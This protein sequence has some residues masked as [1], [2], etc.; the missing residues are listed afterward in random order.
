VACES[1][2]DRFIIQDLK[3][4]II[5]HTPTF[6]RHAHINYATENA[7]CITGTAHHSLLTCH[8]PESPFRAFL[9]CPAPY[10]TPPCSACRHT[11]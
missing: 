11:P 6:S 7:H 9:D 1:A 10:P 3:Q 8:H 4:I 2:I 5:A